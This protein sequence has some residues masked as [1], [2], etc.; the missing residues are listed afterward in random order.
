MPTPARLRM[1]RSIAAVFMALSVLLPA[2]A[3]AAAA[4]DLTLRVGTTQD[5]DAMNPFQT[6]LVVGFEAF[7]LNSQLL[8]G[9]DANLEPSP[10][11]ADSWTK[12]DDGLT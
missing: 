8:L 11:F 9:F 2:A 5:L 1:A 7:T 3:P 6:A 4:N 10:D 12:S